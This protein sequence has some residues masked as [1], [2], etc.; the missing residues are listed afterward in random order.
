MELTYIRT[1]VIKRVGHLLEGGIQ[2]ETMVKFRSI[3]LT[4]VTVLEVYET[5]RNSEYAQQKMQPTNKD[6]LLL[7]MYTVHV[8]S[9]HT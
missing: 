8:A 7:A 4:Y 9:M 2:C 1:W 3:I 5:T 6:E